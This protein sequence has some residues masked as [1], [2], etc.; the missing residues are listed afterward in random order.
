MHLLPQLF[1]ASILETIRAWSAAKSGT[2]QT[3]VFFGVVLVIA[4]VVFCAAIIFR[5]PLTPHRHHHHH[6][7]RSKSDSTTGEEQKPGTFMAQHRRKHRRREHRPV[8]PT[9]SETGGLPAP[10]DGQTPP[11]SQL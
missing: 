5:Q 4:L 11:S 6:R 9:L 2:F 10:R 8:N 1:A 7:P 3:L